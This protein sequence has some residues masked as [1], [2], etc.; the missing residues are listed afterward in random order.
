MSERASGSSAQRPR[1]A[2][3]AQR[4]G[5]VSAPLGSAGRRTPMFWVLLVLVWLW[6]AVPFTYGLVQ[7]I[8]RIPALFSS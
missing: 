3:L 6:V 2:E 5:A 7:L 1:S 4:G 8:G